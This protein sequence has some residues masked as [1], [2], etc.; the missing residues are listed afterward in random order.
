MITNTSTKDD[1]LHGYG[2]GG[3][4]CLLIKEVVS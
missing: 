2:E 4:I 1:N 3:V